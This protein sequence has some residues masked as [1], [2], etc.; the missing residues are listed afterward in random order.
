MQPHA[1]LRSTLK[2]CHMNFVNPTREQFK[3]VY[4]LSSDDAVFMLNLLR[5][6]CVA[7]YQEVDLEHAAP[8]V[9][10]RFAYEKYSEEVEAVFSAA[11]GRQIWIGQPK[12]TVIGP[13]DESWNLTFIAYYP[14]VQAFVNMV[15]TDI[16]QRATRHRTAALQ[17]SRLICCSEL[18]PG[19]SFSPH[20][21]LQA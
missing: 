17:D 4:G 16:Y 21:Y 14:T 9:T 10:G 3:E 7:E 11:G 5:F 15:K 18:R 19:R 1:Y 13:Q 20:S 2:A 6:R 8:S 12:I